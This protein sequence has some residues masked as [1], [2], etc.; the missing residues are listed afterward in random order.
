[1]SINVPT[2]DGNLPLL[3]RNIPLDRPLKVIQFGEGNFLR[4]FVD[5]MVHRLN[6]AGLFHGSIRLV[7]PI[8]HG[9][10]D[11][12]N[13]QEG[14]YTVVLHGIEQGRVVQTVERI[15]A[16]L[17]CVSPHEN[18]RDLIDDFCRDS[19]RFVF[20]NT[21]EAGIQYRPEPYQRGECRISYPAKLTAL[22]YERFLFHGG[23]PDK[24]LFVLPCELI[25]RNGDTLK[26]CVL[27]HAV[28]WNLGEPF[29]GWLNDSNFFLNTLVDRIVTGFPEEEF[30]R[31]CRE[32][33]YVDRLLVCG[34]SFHFFA[35]ECP[36][37]LRQTLEQELPLVQGGL[38]VVLTEHLAPYRERKVRLLNGAHTAVSLAAHLAGH[39]YVDETVRDP[40]FHAYLT[41]LLF[42]EILPSVLLPD[43]EKRNYAE[44]VVKRFANPLVKHRLL[45]IALNSVSKWSV[46]VLPSLCDYRTRTG[47]LPPLMVFS[48]AALVVFYRNRGGIHRLGHRVEDSPEILRFFEQ[49]WIDF[50]QEGDDAGLVERI[51]GHRDLWGQDL[52]DMERLDEELVGMLKNIETAGIRKVIAQL[53][54]F[55]EE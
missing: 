40:L 1:M 20:S 39:V 51:L 25:E 41:Q 53:C 45:S 8:P 17:G 19:V 16:V 6:E 55:N 48:L 26:D 31:L 43:A 37:C 34:E 46:R 52:T 15:T 2:V 28:D 29:I 21:T 24:G 42:E 35:I 50:E 49:A 10:C 32:L 7:Q 9:K 18:W 5:W 4:A 22:M 3:R 12:I 27:R 38:N 36:Q 44:S 23:Q 47:Q 13:A 11:D 30:A 54:S 14:C 33:G